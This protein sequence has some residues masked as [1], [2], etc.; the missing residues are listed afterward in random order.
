M[1]ILLKQEPSF[2]LSVWSNFWKIVTH[3][4]WCRTPVPNTGAEHQ[5]RTRPQPKRTLS[6]IWSLFFLFILYK[7]DQWIESYPKSRVHM[8]KSLH[9]R[10]L[11]FIYTLCGVELRFKPFSLYIHRKSFWI[12]IIFIGSCL[13][14]WFRQDPDRVIIFRTMEWLLYMCIGLIHALF[15]IQN[16]CDHNLVYRVACLIIIVDGMARTNDCINLSIC[17]EA[18]SYH[19]SHRT[20]N[21]LRSLARHSTCH[22]HYETAG[23]NTYPVYIIHR[24]IVTP[25]RKACGDLFCF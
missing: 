7:Y 10:Q 19:N 1:E 16:A 17:A 9:S 2:S 23:Y 12:I 5:C 6:S 15:L 8:I 18:I 25:E 4:H 21:E 11:K 24:W 13:N 14:L 3:S 20:S 22:T